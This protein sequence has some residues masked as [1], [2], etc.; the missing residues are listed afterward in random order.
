MVA[1]DQGYLSLH[2]YPSKYLSYWAVI[3][4]FLY[5]AVVNSAMK[6]HREI[7]RTNDP[8]LPLLNWWVTRLRCGVCHVLGWIWSSVSVRTMTATR[9]CKFSF[10]CHFVFSATNWIYIGRMNLA[11]PTGIQPPTFKLWPKWWWWLQTPLPGLNG[12][13]APFANP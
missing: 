3:F 11:R 5:L 12:L 4:A 7:K 10:S 6:Q 2:D 1:V 13:I 8:E 9:E